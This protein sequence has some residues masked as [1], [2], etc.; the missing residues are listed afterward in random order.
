MDHIRLELRPVA[1]EDCAKLLQFELSNQPYFEQFVPPRPDGF[2]SQRGMEKSVGQLIEE[3]T[4]KT[5]AYYLLKRDQEIVGRFNFEVGKNGAANLGYRLGQNQ[6]GQG[7]A[8]L[9]LKMA[10]TRARVDLNIEK[11][12]AETTLDNLASI[13]VLE[14][15]GFSRIGINISGGVL[16]DQKVDLVQFEKKS[17]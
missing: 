6:T 14:K 10:I 9:G 8:T 12:H 13:R 15:C 3:I 5:G 11:I 2:L 17:P 4:C 1:L 7:L 16:H